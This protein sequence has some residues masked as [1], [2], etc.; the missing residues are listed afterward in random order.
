MCFGGLA[1][2]FGL[3]CGLGFVVAMAWCLVLVFW[4]WCFGGGGVRVFN[5]CVAPVVR[6]CVLCARVWTGRLAL[7]VCAPGW[8]VLAA[9][10]VLVGV[11]RV[12]RYR[13]CRARVSMSRAI[14]LRFL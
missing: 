10:V 13:Y 1:V 9:V 3:S 14:L 4:V 7:G 11:R 8:C 12:R 2:S 5:V 6:V